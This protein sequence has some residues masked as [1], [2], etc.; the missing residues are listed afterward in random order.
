[1]RC[2]VLVRV[3]VLILESGR[4]EDENEALTALGAK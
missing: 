1:M 4:A 2:F 3:V